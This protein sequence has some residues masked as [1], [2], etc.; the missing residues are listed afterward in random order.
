MGSPGSIGLI[1]RRLTTTAYPAGDLLLHRFR[2]LGHCA[3]QR[4]K[5]VARVMELIDQRQDDRQ[6]RVRDRQRSG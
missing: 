1:A 2:L 4:P 6:T 3:R 5:V